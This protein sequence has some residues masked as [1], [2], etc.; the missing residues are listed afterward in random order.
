MKESGQILICRDRNIRLMMLSDLP[1]VKQLV[2][3]IAGS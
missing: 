1:E 3:G 2:D